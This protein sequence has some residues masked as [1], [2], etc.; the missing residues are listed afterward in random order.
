MAIDAELGQAL[1]EAFRPRL[2]VLPQDPKRHR[3]WNNL[4]EQVDV[5]RGDYHPC[6]AEFFL[7]FVFQRDKPR[8]WLQ[9]ILRNP[10]ASA[11]TGLEA[12][13]LRTLGT[14]APAVL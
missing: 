14:A 4:L 2:V 5:P 12:L 13:K 9:S 10:R 3:P 11:P 8:S 1:L 6:S 7:S